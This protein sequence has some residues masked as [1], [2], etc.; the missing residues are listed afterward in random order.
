MLKTGKCGCTS[1]AKC[2]YTWSK[3]KKRGADTLELAAKMTTPDSSDTFNWSYTVKKGGVTIKV[4]VE[5]ARDKDNYSGFI[6][7]S[8]KQ[9]QAKGWEVLEHEGDR[10][11]GTVYRCAMCKWLYK[12]DAE[13]ASFEELPA[14]WKCPE[15]SAAREAFEKIG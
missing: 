1:F 7:P 6:P 11:D 13:D 15:C 14:D 5:D 3:V 12:D 10:E 8:Y 2:C 4:S 9:W